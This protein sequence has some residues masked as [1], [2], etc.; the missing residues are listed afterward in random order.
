MPDDP[1]RPRPSTLPPAGGDVDA[2]LEFHLEMQ[3][4]RFVAQGLSPDAARRQ[5]RERLGDVARVR[6]ACAAIDLSGEAPMTARA[7]LAG[8]RYDVRDAWRALRRAPLH[9]FACAATLAVAIGATAA[10]FT[11][12]NAVLLARLPY[13]HAD[14]LV[15]VWN[16]YGASL[17]QAAVS[18]PEFAD[19]LDA[20]RAFDAL[21][22]ITVQ[23][24][25]LGG[26]CGG[27]ADCAPER[28]TS[29]VASAG[30]FDVLGVAPALGAGFHERGAPAEGTEV[31]LTDALWRR[32]YGSDPAI[33]GR[34]VRLDGRV[35]TVVGVMPPG[36]RFPDAPLGFLREPADLW[37][38]Y[39]WTLGRSGSRGDQN[40][41]VVARL[42]EGLGIADARAELDRREAQFTAAFPGRYAGEARQWSLMAVP[43]LEQMV[44]DVRTALVVLFGA[45]GLVLLIACANVANLS[46]ARAAS[47]RR[48]IA[49]RA[50]LGAGRA[51]L[52]R[53][54]FTEAL[55]LASAGGVAGFGLATAGLAALKALDPGIPRLAAA[56][57]DLRV[58]LFGLALV[59]GTAVLAG[60]LP[61][62]RLSGTTPRGALQDGGARGSGH[63][64]IATTLRRGLVVVEVTLAVVVL[65][66]AGLLMRS[67]S[68]LTA[69]PTGVD[70][71]ETV[72]FQV[73]PPSSSYE[74]GERLRELHTRLV[75][76]LGALPG[77][78]GVSA[79]SPMPL[80]GGGWSGSFFIPGLEVPEGQPEPH[81]EFSAV[82]PGAFQALGISMLEG[83]DFTAFDTTGAPGVVVVDQR[84]ADKYWPG[85]SAI[86]QRLDTDGRLDPSEATVIGVVRHIHRAGPRDDGE[87]QIYLPLRQYTLRTV[88]FTLGVDGDPA[89]VRTSLRAAIDDVDA[90]LPITD[91]RT[92]AERRGRLFSPDR[93]NAFVLSLFAGVALLLAVVGLSAVLASL[94]T[95]RRREIGIRLALGG[96][97]AGVVRRVIGEGLATAM[98]GIAIG[99]GA[100][101]VLSRGLAGLLF[102]VTATDAGT[103]LAIG[104]LLLGTAAV[105]SW[106]PARRATRV[107]PVEV[108]QA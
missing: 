86:G 37:V 73:T 54:V 49:V 31:V 9:A 87:P 61:A 11:V 76:R 24:V 107:N 44:G 41:A 30:L 56:S 38:A 15:M 80:A 55:L 93:F 6:E 28:V 99:L 92:M 32:R 29:Y 22:A 63:S 74:N 96:R 72:T 16:S 45:V 91:V 34:A 69:A 104:L 89:P 3:T 40:L 97:P 68:A 62:W 94:V 20:P 23:P 5:A 60:L 51:R 101:M 65:V 100:A 4:R 27:G 12:F 50:A 82:L 2:E 8:W 46:L 85:R 64:A 36:I 21:A 75:E 90:G 103:Y 59:A 47:R 67:L 7:W 70:G 10:M 66:G 57:I 35:V 26:A 106:I 14:R 71:R 13:R 81:A 48:D 25:G 84:L 83:R 88:Y 19:L 53:Q 42:R 98:V 52:V 18:A 17:P 95:E 78:R 108:L 58:L 39:D 105:A 77:V 43:V 33:V 1:R 79:I 102:G